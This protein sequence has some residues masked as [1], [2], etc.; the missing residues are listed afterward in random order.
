[1]S[2]ILKE[3]LPAVFKEK[4][5]ANTLDEGSKRWFQ[6]LLKNLTTGGVQSNISS[7]NQSQSQSNLPLQGMQGMQGN[8]PS[9]MKN[10]NMGNMQ[11]IITR[12][13]N[14]NPESLYYMPT[15]NT[16]YSGFSTNSYD[17]YYFNNTFQGDS[18]NPYSYKGTS[19]MPVVGLGGSSQMN[20]NTP[21]YNFEGGKGSK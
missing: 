7:S 6:S 9:N 4:N 15:S 16:N 3:N 12:D 8:N 5:F 1:M 17:P 2:S 19:S 18:S 14:S 10:F 20:M 13:T 11:N 21:Y